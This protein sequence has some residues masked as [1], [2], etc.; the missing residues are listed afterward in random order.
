MDDELHCERCGLELVAVVC[1]AVD[2]YGKPC[3]RPMFVNGDDG[4][5]VAVR[6][7]VHGETFHR[8]TVTGDDSAHVQAAH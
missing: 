5:Y 8:I 6:C 4:L 3:L 7:P 1:R 2:R